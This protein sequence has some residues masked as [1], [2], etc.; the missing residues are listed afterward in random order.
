VRWQCRGFPIGFDVIAGVRAISETLPLSIVFLAN[1]NI[2]ADASAL[3]QDRVVD[4]GNAG[5]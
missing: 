4:R 2:T 5:D 1:L 3:N